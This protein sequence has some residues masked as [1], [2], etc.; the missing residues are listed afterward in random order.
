MQGQNKF[1]RCQNNDGHEQSFFFCRTDLSPEIH[2]KKRSWLL[3]ESTAVSV[4]Q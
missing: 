3:Q 2:A 1:P 4:T